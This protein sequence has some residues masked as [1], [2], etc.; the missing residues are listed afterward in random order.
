MFPKSAVH[1]TSMAY[2]DI[3]GVKI[4]YLSAGAGESVLLLHGWGCSIESMTPVFDE[5]VKHYA[6]VALDFPGHGESELPPRAW[7]VTDFMVMVLRVMDALHLDRPHIIAHS[8][9]GRVAIKLAATYPDRVGK[10][11][12]VDS[13]GIRPSRR[14]KYYVR[15]SLA[16][17]GKFLAAYGGR[18]GE[19]MRQRIY[20]SV[21]SQDYAAAGPLRETFVKLVN[22][23]LTSELP[24][25]QAPTLLVWGE[26]DTDTPVASA[27]IMHQLIPNAELVV[28][29][30]AGHFSYLDQFGKF[31]LIVGKFLRQ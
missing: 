2:L 26:N 25:I 12:L 23:D 4:R 13:A 20:A 27:K 1:T 9:G 16:K 19:R 3:D 8:H 7:N 30:H 6:V 29:Q 18:W 14:F 28:L 21:A 31:R 5:F 24:A 11:V 10:I 17:I 15:V 22:A